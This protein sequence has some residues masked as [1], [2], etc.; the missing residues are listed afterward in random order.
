MPGAVAEAVRTP[1]EIR[2]RAIRAGPIN[3][4]DPRFERGNNVALS[5][6]IVGEALICDQAVATLMSRSIHCIFS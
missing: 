5:D 1:F 4:R 3:L 2:Q 6:F